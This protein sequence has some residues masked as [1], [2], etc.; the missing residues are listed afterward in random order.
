MGATSCSQR[1]LRGICL[2]LRGPP[3]LQP[4]PRG[5]SQPTGGHKGPAS[6]RLSARPW[7]SNSTKKEQLVTEGAWGCQATSVSVKWQ[8]KSGQEAGPMLW[9][10]EETATLTLQPRAC[11]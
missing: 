7:P 3:E 5:S 6:R 9:A 10:Q 11:A 1:T 2:H 8:L 4:L